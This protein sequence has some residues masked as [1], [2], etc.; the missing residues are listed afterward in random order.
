MDRFIT[1][2]G[3]PP[4]KRKKSTTS[5]KNGTITSFFNSKASSS[6]S[7]SNNKKM[8]TS[9]DATNVETE[10]KDNTLT[11]STTSKRKHKDIEKEKTPV[12][13][14]KQALTP[15]STPTDKSNS[16]NSTLYLA[17]E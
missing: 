14:M 7:S 13:E 6:S 16:D 3:V 5:N 9:T 10:K 1:R 12:V 8:K 15:G 4:P 11:P 17:G 2:N